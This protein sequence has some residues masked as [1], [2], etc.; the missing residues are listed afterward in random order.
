MITKQIIP[1]YIKIVIKDFVKKNRECHKAYVVYDT[2]KDCI[3]CNSRGFMIE[4]A[5]I[6]ACLAWLKR[7]AAKSKRRAENRRKRKERRAEKAKRRSVENAMVMTD[8]ELKEA[9]NNIISQ[10]DPTQEYQKIDIRSI[11]Q[12]Y[13]PILKEY[14]EKEISDWNSQCVKRGDNYIYRPDYNIAHSELCIYYNKVSRTIY[15]D[16]LFKA[17]KQNDRFVI[18]DTETGEILDDA[19]GYGYTTAHKAYKCYG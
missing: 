19:Q 14:I 12:K 10:L 4:D 13:K 3:V 7:K 1:D 15:T 8:E 17:V 5:A 2:R 16:N 18:I 11:Y 6:K 9:I